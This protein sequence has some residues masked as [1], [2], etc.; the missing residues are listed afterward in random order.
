MHSYINDNQNEVQHDF[1]WSVTPLPK[2]VVQH[3][4]NS[5]VNGMVA[6]FRKIEMRCNMTFPS[7]HISGVSTGII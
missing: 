2:V 4:A 3:D 7:C 1:F 5:A 6:F